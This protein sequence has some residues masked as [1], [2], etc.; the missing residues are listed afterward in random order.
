MND[1]RPN[2]SINR[3]IDEAAT[4]FVRLREPDL[5]DGDRQEFADWLLSSTDHVREYLGMAMLG[6]DISKPGNT[7]CEAE[8]LIAATQRG[9]FDGAVVPLFERDVATASASQRSHRSSAR[10]RRWSLAAAVITAFSF[11]LSW[12]YFNQPA[13]TVK[14]VIGEQ[15][16]L[17][18]QDGSLL[19]LNTQSEIR[20]D[21]SNDYRDVYLLSGEALFEVAKDSNRPFRVIA[22]GAVI[23]AV[24][25]AFNVHRRYHNA[26]VTVVEG[27]VDVSM[28]DNSNSDQI[29]DKDAES[30][31][32]DTPVRLGI[33]QQARI[34][35]QQGEIK[36]ATV[37]P[38]KAVAW[39]ERRLIFE[40]EPLAAAVDA[41]NRYNQDKIVIA[42]PVL[43]SVKVSGVFST[44]GRESFS[45]FLQ[46]AN[47]AK[48]SVR[49]DT[50]VLSQL[51]ETK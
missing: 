27:I 1:N 2:S 21:Y 43:E 47:L 48:I 28:G 51:E 19:V 17:S 37:D 49:E 34:D 45:R 16:S 6:D 25:T 46:E 18:L 24:G 39:R 33:G 22:D 26:T 50:I 12:F 3:A 41:F 8:A 9:V 35:S 38:S 44:H 31:S 32:L 7:V 10:W 20:L 29:R 42:N 4:W 40:S 13:D 11:G 14:T 23:Q 30:K 36:V 5:S 15:T